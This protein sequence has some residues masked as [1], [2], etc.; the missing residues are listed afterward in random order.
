MNKKE[1][2][3]KL[4]SDLN[5]LYESHGCGVRASAA[6]APKVYYHHYSRQEEANFRH[7]YGN[8]LVGLVYGDAECQ[9]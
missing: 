7:V 6:T 1:R 3:A 2:K 9:Q 8:E 5:A 4:I